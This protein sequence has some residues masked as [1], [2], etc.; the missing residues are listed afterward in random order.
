MMF[1]NGNNFFH[2]SYG[3]TCEEDR[4]T[5]KPQI[6][7]ECCLNTNTST[8]RISWRAR[9]TNV[10]SF[11]SLYRITDERRKATREKFKQINHQ[12]H[13]KVFTDS[14]WCRSSHYLHLTFDFNTPSQ[15]SLSL[16]ITV[17]KHLCEEL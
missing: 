8:K 5:N 17:F 10:H 4:K 12:N 9:G 15:T 6:L 11:R 2:E 7:E 13:N 14:G 16:E 1:L 3:K